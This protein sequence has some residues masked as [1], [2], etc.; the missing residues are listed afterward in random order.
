MAEVLGVVGFGT[1]GSEIALLGACAGLRVFVFEPSQE[2]VA[3][4]TTRLAKVARMIARD[5]KFFAAAALADAEREK[6][7]ARIRQ[8]EAL[9]GLK[10]C[11]VVIEAVPESMELKSRIFTELASHTAPTALL[12][13]NTSSISITELAAK[14]PQPERFLGM[15]FFNPP[16]AM[17]LVEVVPGM[18]TAEENVARALELAKVLGKKAIRV[19]ETPGFVVNR[20]LVAMMVEAIRVHEDGIASIQD[21]DE[22]MRLGANFPVGPFKL[23]DLVGLDVLEHASQVIYNELGQDKFRPPHSLKTLVRA[24]RLGR[25]TKHGFYKY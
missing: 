9:S 7:L 20:V 6:T 12:A 17:Q 4:N 24:G 25:K 10:D 11:T 18:A 16:S 15:H 5:P 1:M 19:K 2:I 23:A 21:I 8:V 13:T 22:A 14:L 3:A